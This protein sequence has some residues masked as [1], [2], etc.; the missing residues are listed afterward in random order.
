MMP[1]TKAELPPAFYELLSKWDTYSLDQKTEMLSSLKSNTP[2]PSPAV[3][4]KQLPK[5]SCAEDVLKYVTHIPDFFDDSVLYDSLMSDFKNLSIRP[6][7]RNKKKRKSLWLTNNLRPY[8]F[9]N[10]V[11]KAQPLDN[12][13]AISKIME[14]VNDC[15]DTTQD[16]DAC[17]VTCYSAP[18]AALS[19]HSD[20]EEHDIDQNSSINT[21]SIGATRQLEYCNNFDNIALKT[22]EVSDGTLTI[23]KPGCQ[24]VLR[25]R[26]CK[27]KSIRGASNIRFSLSFRKMAT[28]DTTSNA[29]PTSPATTPSTSRNISSTSD[30]LPS[31]H[32]LSSR[33]KPKISLMAGD[34]FF[35]RLNADKLG[36]R[37]K[38]VVNI[39][40]GGSK[41][42]QTEN[43]IKKFHRENVDYNVDKV[44][45]S[46]GTND[47][48][49]CYDNGVKH[50]KP[51]VNKLIKV[52]KEL[53]PSAKIYVQSLIPLPLGNRFTSRN[54]LNFNNLL[55]DLCVKNH[56]YYV[57]VFHNLLDIKGCKRN[58]ALFPREESDCHPNLRGMGVL[59]K[60]YIFLIH[61][62]RFNPLG[63]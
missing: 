62:R 16:S 13:P 47:I 18:S 34:S 41:L 3:K 55:Y 6:G 5:P 59:A 11:H 15:K 61:S 25:H 43:S 35:E 7:P 32:K 9:S 19:L 23:M 44:F 52:V 27:G 20:N 54:V 26:I 30:S 63:F 45:L 31:T 58:P 37:K 21:L 40:K 28:P 56:I 42:T 22:F 51:V 49:H 33:P 38:K 17:L 24:Q 1:S 50:L 48:R 10:I 2:T 60:V 46:I 8:T 36:K 14:L 39:A 29:T 53:F 57:N 12:Y 4:V